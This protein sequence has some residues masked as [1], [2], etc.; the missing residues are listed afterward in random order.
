VISDLL[1]VRLQGFC[2][3]DRPA[4]VVRSLRPGSQHGIPTVIADDDAWGI[5]AR[6]GPG[7]GRENR[8]R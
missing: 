4:E 8:L 5:E 2:T 3:V 1:S 6:R 7:S